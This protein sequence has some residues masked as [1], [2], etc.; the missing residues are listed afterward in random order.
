[1]TCRSARRLAR[2]MDVSTPEPPQTCRRYPCR[3]RRPAV[4]F[5]SVVS[6]THTHWNLQ[7]GPWIAGELE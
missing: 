4:P 2:H 6:L 5:V 3:A 7:F 1:M